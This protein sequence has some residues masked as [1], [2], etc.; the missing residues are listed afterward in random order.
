MNSTSP[1][2]TVPSVRRQSKSP[3]MSFILTLVFLLLINLLNRP[4]RMFNTAVVFAVLF[5]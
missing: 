4:L 2:E 3:F 5:S 1:S